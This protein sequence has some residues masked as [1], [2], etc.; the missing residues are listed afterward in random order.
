MSVH[1]AIHPLIIRETERKQKGA[2]GL[3]HL[4][5]VTE[6]VNKSLSFIGLSINYE[7]CTEIIVTNKH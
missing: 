3:T 6:I 7:S 5:W 4:M 1:P 2:L